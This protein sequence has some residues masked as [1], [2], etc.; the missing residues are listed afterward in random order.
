MLSPFRMLCCRALGARLQGRQYHFGSHERPHEDII[1]VSSPLEGVMSHT[2]S[3][4]P[5]L[6]NTI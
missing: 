3:P 6:L 5:L 2:K 4:R 1:E